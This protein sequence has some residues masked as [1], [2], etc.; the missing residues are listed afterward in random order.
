MSDQE[1]PSYR[2]DHAS[3]I[4]AIQ[5]LINL[6]YTY[7]TPEKAVRLRGGK[8]GGVLLDGILWGQNSNS[9]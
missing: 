5:L 8:T 7:V 1:L 9:G 3:Q 6:G 2:E 4:P